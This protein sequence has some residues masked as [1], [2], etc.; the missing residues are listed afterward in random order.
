MKTTIALCFALLVLLLG[1]AALDAFCPETDCATDTE[2]RC[3]ADCL[4]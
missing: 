3:G 1:I 2:C 4:E